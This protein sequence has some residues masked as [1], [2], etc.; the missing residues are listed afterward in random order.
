M[1]LY[2]EK[3]LGGRWHP[4]EFPQVKNEIDFSIVVIMVSNSFDFSL[5]GNLV[6]NFKK[7]A[8]TLQGLG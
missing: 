5:E 4:F 2:H 1:P 3:M 6:P 7:Q 8:C